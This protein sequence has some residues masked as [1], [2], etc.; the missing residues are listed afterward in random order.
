MVM[1]MEKKINCDIIKDL[2]PLYQDGVCSDFSREII[3]EHLEECADCKKIA[4][5]L[6][7]SQLE[8]RLL[9]EKDDILATHF[10][11]ER[12]R[13][14]TIGLYTAGILMIP[15]IVCLICNLAIGLR[16]DWFFIVLTSLLLT[17]SVTVV[18]LMVPENAGLWT[19]GAF[20]VSL[21]LLLFTICIYTQGNWFFVTAVPVVFGLSVLFA[22]YVIGRLPLPRALAGQKG[23]IVML[24]DTLWLY[25]LIVVCGFYVSFGS[26]EWRVALQITSFS[27]LL[28]WMLFLIIRYCRFHPL[29][30]AGICT[31]LA[32]IFCAFVNDVIAWILGEPERLMRNADFVLWN[33]AAYNAVNFCAIL[34]VTM[35]LGV[36]LIAV[37]VVKQH[38][39]NK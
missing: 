7:N 22:P 20:T 32:G 36:L 15:V 2:L 13:T 11:K 5:K 14:F 25:A 6:K 35:P 26:Y 29:I 8:E 27:I 38:K 3:E 24:W 10:K 39:A 28:P 17:A 1:S 12:K 18:P 19:L 23:V 31:V 34:I 9:Q 33:D 30:K 16:L 4:D 37:G 21:L